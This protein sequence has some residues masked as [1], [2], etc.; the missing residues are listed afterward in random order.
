MILASLLVYS[1]PMPATI[2]VDGQ[3]SVPV[4]IPAFP[5]APTRLQSVEIVYVFD[6][7]H[8]AAIENTASIPAPA[9]HMQYGATHL[10][11]YPS[12]ALVPGGAT[13]W[14]LHSDPPLS[15]F[16]GAV[17]FG[18]TSG[19]SW[20]I[21]SGYTYSRTL[22]FDS[23]SELRPFIQGHPALFTFTPRLDASITMP[24]DHWQAQAS[25]DIHVHASH[26]LVR[27]TYQ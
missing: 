19:A 14:Y 23:P 4:S 6:H 26:A 7:R 21:Q 8:S 2:T 15:A 11:R 20:S 13:Y 24:A 10:W 12:G 1:V 16:D 9:W 3:E 5:L 18:G 22:L 27:Y 17:D 25:I